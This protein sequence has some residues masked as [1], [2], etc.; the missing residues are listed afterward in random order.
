MDSFCAPIRA[1]K[2]PVCGVHGPVGHPVVFPVG[3]ARE[4]DTG[5]EVACEYL[6]V[7]IFKTGIAIY[8]LFSKSVIKLHVNFLRL[9]HFKTPDTRCRDK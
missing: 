4:P 7:K 1:A 8:L 3:G 6:L 5:E 9:K 2:L